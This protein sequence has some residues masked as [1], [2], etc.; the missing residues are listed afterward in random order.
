MSAPM[1]RILG[2]DPG[3]QHTGWGVIESDGH[4]IKY[5]ASGVCHSKADQPMPTRLL[6]LQTLLSQAIVGATP[7][8]AAMEETF[9]NKNP[10]SSLK[11]GHARGA[12]MLT[13]ALAGLSLTEYAPTVV[14]KT[15]TGKGRAEKEQVQGMLHYVL[16]G[17]KIT[18]PDEAD[19]LAVALC[20]AYH[21]P[22]RKL[23]AL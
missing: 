9:V 7:H 14:K 4:R 23:R 3:L 16:P 20:H 5:I 19:A 1:I 21:L 2:I 13:V 18:N 22:L 17:T 8:E 12:L 6:S 11:L 15:V 10:V